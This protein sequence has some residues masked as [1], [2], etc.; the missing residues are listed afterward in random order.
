MKVGDKLYCYNGLSY[1]EDDG[2]DI[3]VV[4]G[5]SYTI[6]E[7]DLEC[8]YF[9]FQSLSVEGESKALHN[10]SLEPIFNIDNREYY[11]YRNWFLT[12]REYRKLKLKK[13]NRYESL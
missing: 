6:V 5:K 7:I 9:D 4:S 12:E 13:I 2:G 10:F 3:I 1:S 8:Q 11:S